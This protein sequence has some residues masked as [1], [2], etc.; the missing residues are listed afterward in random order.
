[1]QAKA[2]T[3][4]KEQSHLILTIVL[5]QNIGLFHQTTEQRVSSNVYH[6]MLVMV[7]LARHSPVSYTKSGLLQLIRR[8]GMINRIGAWVPP[9]LTNP[10]TLDAAWRDWADYETVKR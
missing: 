5:L 1:M 9:D 10:Q 7:C 3:D 4:A 2:P 8:T 6:G